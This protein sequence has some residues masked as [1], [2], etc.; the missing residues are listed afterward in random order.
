MENEIEITED[1]NAQNDSSVND[2]L[3]Q[4]SELAI[5]KDTQEST[6]E[7]L[8]KDRISEMISKARSDEKSKVYGQLTSL[9]EQKAVSDAKA[10]ELADKIASLENDLDSVRKGKSTELDSVTQELS[11]F[12]DTNKKLE[13]AIEE[14]ANKA[15]LQIR[16]AKLDAYKE[17]VIAEKRLVFV[18]SV[19]GSTEEEILESAEKA[20]KKQKLIEEDARQRA[21]DEARRGLIKDLPKPLVVDGQLGKGPNPMVGA[22][23]R[24]AFAKLPDAEYKKQRA[25][26][27]EEAKR[28]VGLIE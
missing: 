23:N 15:T 7:P 27:L 6:K 12:R 21:L 8:S 2:K 19:N 16:Q 20:L 17:K 14:V 4:S 18:E 22:A 3:E 9:K 25:I 28:K 11:R 26:L 5:K 10:K 24:E 1:T 13:A